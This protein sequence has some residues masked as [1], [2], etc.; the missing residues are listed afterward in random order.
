MDIVERIKQ[1]CREYNISV[2]YIEKKLGF[3]NGYISKI[4]SDTVTYER[5]SKIAEFLRVTPQF[6]FTGDYEKTQMLSED[7]QALLSAYR[8][9][10]LHAKMRA[11]ENIQDMTELS[12][13]TRRYQVEKQGGGK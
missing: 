1:L 6:L 12:K 13:N 11:L 9:L 5:L 10:N 2:S 8:M 7:E 3:A 4:K